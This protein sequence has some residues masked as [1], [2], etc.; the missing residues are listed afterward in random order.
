LSD[1]QQPKIMIA[2]GEKP[3]DIRSVTPPAWSDWPH[4]SVGKK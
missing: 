1:S 2:S 4:V 3:C